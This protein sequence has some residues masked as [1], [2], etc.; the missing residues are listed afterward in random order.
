MKKIILSTLAVALVLAGFWVYTKYDE[1][2]VYPSLRAH[3]N[4]HMKDPT[5]TQFRNER[6]TTYGWLCGEMNAKNGMGGYGGFVRYIAGS[7]NDAYVEGIGKLEQS[8]DKSELPS[9]E[10]IVAMIEKKIEVIKEATEVLMALRTANPD[11]KLEKPSEQEIEA[12]AMTKYF[13]EKWDA[14]CKN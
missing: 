13:S 4:T 11:M 14:N 6:L 8:T 12:K 1:W 7:A 10:Y 2:F 3:V 5:N 9:T